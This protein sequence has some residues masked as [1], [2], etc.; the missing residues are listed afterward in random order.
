VNDSYRVTWSQ[1]DGEHVGLC[2]EFPSL[3][4]LAS[5]P[6]AAL[7]G[8]RRTV[9][10]GVADMKRNREEIPVPL[11]EKV[12][13]GQFK[14]PA[15]AAGREAGRDELTCPPTEEGAPAEFG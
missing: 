7:A 3:S 1:K 15:S 9:A 5:T 4:W 14:G 11:A 8:I 2:V 6:E 10:R 13:S 12:Y